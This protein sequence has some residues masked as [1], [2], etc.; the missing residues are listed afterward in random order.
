MRGRRARRY[1]YIA[2]LAKAGFDDIAIEETRQYS[3]EDARMFL[4]GEGLDVD[5]LAR[6]V[7]GT[8]IS[9]FI[10]ATKPAPIG[11][12]GPSCCN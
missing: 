11:C 12:C 4:A 9:G 10:R 5:A 7:D 3:L 6:Q 1:E 8:F 2:K